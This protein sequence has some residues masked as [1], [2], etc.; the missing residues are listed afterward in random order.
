MRLFTHAHSSHC[1]FTYMSKT[2]QT[3][4]SSI[5]PSLED[6]TPATDYFQV[7][8]TIGSHF[9]AAAISNLLFYILPC[10]MT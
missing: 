8:S 3:Q 5:A 2:R 1:F 6:G 10:P 7:A 9:K 4:A